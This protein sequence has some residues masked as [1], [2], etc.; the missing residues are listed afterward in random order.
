[1]FLWKKRLIEFTFQYLVL[2][3]AYQPMYWYWYQDG[4]PT[5]SILA[6]WDRFFLFTLYL[7]WLYFWLIKW[8]IKFIKQ[9]PNWLELVFSSLHR[10][11][12]QMAVFLLCCQNCDFYVFVALLFFCYVGIAFFLIQLCVLECNR[13]MVWLFYPV[14]LFYTVVIN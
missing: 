2:G 14:P 13:G 4:Y 5:G 3:W 8:R 1:M 10:A 7:H 12:V 11:H 9:S 6:H